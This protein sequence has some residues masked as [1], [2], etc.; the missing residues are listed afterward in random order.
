MSIF[1]TIKTGLSSFVAKFTS[2]QP[3][4]ATKP[5]LPSGVVLTST[6]FTGKASVPTPVVP[7]PFTFVE[8]LQNAAILTQK[9]R[10][11]IAAEG[12]VG[13]TLALAALPVVTTVGGAIATAGIVGGTALAVPT[14]ISYTVAHPGNVANIPSASLDL[15]SAVSNVVINPSSFLSESAKYLKTHPVAS[16]LIGAG[17]VTGAVAAGGLQLAAAVENRANV[18]DALSGIDKAIG[19]IPKTQRPIPTPAAPDNVKPPQ[20]ASPVPI[21]PAT[22]V[23]GKSAG[24][25]GVKRHKKRKAKP[26][27]SIRINNYLNNLTRVSR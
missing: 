14:A 5:S 21:T 7:K 19:S 27:G 18:S 23:I 12:L 17:V 13:G 15:A 3:T 16:G 9:N 25:Y 26:V 11:V 2:P 1:D 8:R 10:A 6:G 22:Q 20:T 4:V 24:T